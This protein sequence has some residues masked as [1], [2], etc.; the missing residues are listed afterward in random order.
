MKKERQE[1]END[2][3]RLEETIKKVK[4]VLQLTEQIMRLK[5]PIRTFFIFA[6]IGWFLS[7]KRGN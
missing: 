2:R 7:H 6:A 4:D 1:V 3:R 5:I